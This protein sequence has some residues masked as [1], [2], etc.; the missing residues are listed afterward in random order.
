MQ[1]IKRYPMPPRDYFPF[2]KEMIN[3][4][5]DIKDSQDCTFANMTYSDYKIKE[6]PSYWNLVEQF[7]QPAF[8]NYAESWSCKGVSI[9]SMW[10]AEYYNGANFNWHTHEGCNLS[11]VI[12]LHGTDKYSTELLGNDLRIVA[13]DVVVFPSMLPHRG[14]TVTGHKVCIGINAELWGSTLHNE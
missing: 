8:D 5:E 9:R 12:H 10:F 7:V 14:P 6:R 3:H 2:K 13:G 11:A 4:M 1:F